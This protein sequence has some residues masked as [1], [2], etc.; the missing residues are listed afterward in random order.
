MANLGIDEFAIHQS[1]K[2]GAHMREWRLK[3]LT[4]FRDMRADCT[5]M[6]VCLASRLH[7][8]VSSIVKGV[9]L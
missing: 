5:D 2:M 4:S 7:P 6:D 8:E 1:C 3:R 9:P